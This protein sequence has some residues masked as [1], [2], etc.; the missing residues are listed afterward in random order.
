M[1]IQWNQVIVALVVGLLLGA[2]FGVSR[3]RPFQGAPRGGDQH[4]QRML[5]RFNRKLKLTPQ[6][7][8]EVARILAAKRAKLEA[9]ETQTKP[10]FEEVRAATNSEIRQLLLA[11]QQVKFDAMRSRWEARRAK[12]G[13]R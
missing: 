1:K 5:E 12:R 11:E 8:E 4:Y 9:L 10:K 6:Q 13:L 3:G 7:K 2:A